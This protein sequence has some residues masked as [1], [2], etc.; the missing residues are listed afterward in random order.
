MLNTKQL[1]V[2]LRWQL[3]FF[4]PWMKE[5]LPSV[6][7]IRYFPTAPQQ[8][9]K[10]KIVI[11]QKSKHAISML[12]WLLWFCINFFYFLKHQFS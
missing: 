6:V 4:L 2:Y 7:C 11:N 12:Q 9:K 1:F 8:N 5:D 3:P 10:Y